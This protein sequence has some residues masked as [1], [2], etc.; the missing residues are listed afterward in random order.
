MKPEKAVL[1]V[2]VAVSTLAC[3]TTS[4]PAP[5]HVDPSSSAIAIYIDA[6]APIALF[7]SDFDEVFFANLKRPGDSVT[8]TNLIPSNFACDGYYYLMYAP[9]GTYVAVACYDVD[10]DSRDQ[11]GETIDMGG[12]VT[13][14][15]GKEVVDYSYFTVFFDE[16]M[17]RLTELT[18]E[19]GTISYMGNYLIQMS[20]GVKDADEVQYHYFQLLHP[21]GSSGWFADGL[22][23]EHNY[24]GRL[25]EAHYDEQAEEKFLQEARA[26]LAE[27]EWDRMLIQP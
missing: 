1:S 8:Q 19:P 4:G 2:V 11:F 9:P 6:R 14:V 10:V 24:R 23:G 20:V 16:E 17:V 18:T 22:G 26:H 25:K 27:T 12:G 21:E 5:A 15:L 3:A 7:S 13:V